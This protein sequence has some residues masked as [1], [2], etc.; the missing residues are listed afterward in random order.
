M[1]YVTT[2]IR[3]PGTDA[4][5]IAPA[6]K[7]DMR[8][9][10][11]ARARSLSAAPFVVMV[12]ESEEKDAMMAICKTLMAALRR[13]RLSVVSCAVLTAR[14][15]PALRIAQMEFW[16]GMRSAMMGTGRMAMDAVQHV[17]S[18]LDGCSPAK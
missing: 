8:A 12:S 15:V 14:E 4:H 3:F 16:L 2:A 5:R 10:K 18:N 1:R 11:L 17:L 13:A 6:S 7:M 9:R